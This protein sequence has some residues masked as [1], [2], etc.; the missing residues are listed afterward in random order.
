LNYIRLSSVAALVVISAAQASSM[1]LNVPSNASLPLD[2]SLDV[3]ASVHIPAGSIG[4]IGLSVDTS[5]LH[6]TS[7]DVAV[8]VEPST[9]QIPASAGDWDAPFKVHFH[10]LPGSHSFKS[11]PVKVIAQVSGNNPTLSQTLLLT[12]AA[13]YEIDLYGGKIP[14]GWSS[15]MTLSMP[16]HD[17]GVTINF[18]NLDTTNTHT[19]HGEE[20]IPHQEGDPLAEAT[21]NGPGGVYT[22]NVPSGDPV[23]GYYRC[24]DHETEDML[25]SISFNN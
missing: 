2:R 9:I 4:S 19:I 23:M 20:A 21:A 13:V 3:N 16:K 24:H 11:L 14:E 15:P 6:A 10:T 5:S 8:T 25:R 22:I 12:V 7:T 18:V 17:G 1:A